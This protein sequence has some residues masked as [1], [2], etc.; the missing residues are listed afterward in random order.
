MKD[1]RAHLQLFDLIARDWQL[2]SPA[3][4]I[5][6]NADTSAVAFACVDGSVHLA[7]TADKASPTLRTRRAIDT[8]RLTIA[9]REKPFLPLKVAEFT[10]GRSSDVVA[11]GAQG[12]A[13][14]KTSGRINA[15]SAGGIAYH[16]PPRAQ[17]AIS[18]LT[19]SAD[20]TT[21]AYASGAQ[22]YIATAETTQPQMIALPGVISAVAF[23]PDGLTLAVAHG[24]VV[25]RLPLQALNS[26][27]IVTLL[28]EPSTALHWHP[29]NNWLACTLAADGFY[30][31]DTA[32]NHV[33]HRSK[34]PAPVRSA[35]FGQASKTVVASGAFRVAAWALE[36]G[37]DVVTGKA[38][39]VLVNAVA[40]CP[41]RNLV[42]V[43]YA[44]GLLSLAEIGQ[45]SEILLREDTGAGISAMV[46]SSDGRFLA[47]AG[48]DGSAALVEFPDAMFKS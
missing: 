9:A 6:F 40:T 32:R 14:A 3:Q 44:N 27:P 7:D 39:L 19:A 24:R 11:F 5:S 48:S 12:F 15:L 35:G 45:P 10:D 1:E 37:R 42:A 47:L 31:I 46:W 41:T 20:G 16:V 38:G 29:D 17:S 4:Q 13:F 28:T 8:G 30:L 21:L 43:G 33:L 26:Q 2:A 36:D 22:L 25:W 18:V 34:F 23:S